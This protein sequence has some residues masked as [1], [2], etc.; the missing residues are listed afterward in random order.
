MGLELGK[1][2]LLMILMK[3]EGNLTERLRKVLLVSHLERPFEKS[4]NQL[5]L[6]L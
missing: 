2:L 5:F 4:L 6:M 3:R 1:L